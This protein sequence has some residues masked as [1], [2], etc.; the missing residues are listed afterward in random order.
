MR[1]VDAQIEEQALQLLQ[2]VY[3]H[4]GADTLD[5]WGSKRYSRFRTRVWRYLQQADGLLS[6]LDG[7][8]EFLPGANMAAVLEIVDSLM[9]SEAVFDML[10]ERLTVLVGRLQQLNRKAREARETAIHASN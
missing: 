9:D 8:F 1:E 3:R 5:N 10:N 4:T 2:A 6:F 7:Y